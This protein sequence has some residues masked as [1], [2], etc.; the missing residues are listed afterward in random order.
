M[1]SF[2][3]EP[4][5]YVTS[6]NGINIEYQSYTCPC[7]AIDLHLHQAI[8]VLYIKEGIFEVLINDKSFTVSGGDLVL[9][10]KYALHSVNVLSQNGG[11]Y[12][13]LKIH[14]S[15]LE[16]F[17]TP[18]TVATI[19]SFFV[20]DTK[21]AIC[22]KR[23]DEL[24]NSDILSSL[25]EIIREMKS[26]NAFSFFSLKV[27]VGKFLL[28]FLREFYKSS[29]DSF[30]CLEISE[31]LSKTIQKA[32]DYINSNYQNNI[33]ANGVAKYVG[34]SYNYFSNCFS[35]VTGQT[36]RQYL[37]KTRIKHAKHLLLC[38]HLNINEI[39]DAVGYNS[40]S[41]F[42]LEFRRQTGITPAKFAKNHSNKKPLQY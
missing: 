18:D 21:E 17:T 26:E 22:I 30:N 38:S 36:F 32:V 37:N 7:V 5:A 19:Q 15:I 33:T 31:N 6:T 23:S 42:I 8:E 39:S 4:D 29:P 13:V 2:R 27:N 16:D 10:R 24:K 9:L 34:L 20:I 12:Y 1:N 40:V 41:Y 25:E 3:V 28:S 35:Q 14:P 11:G